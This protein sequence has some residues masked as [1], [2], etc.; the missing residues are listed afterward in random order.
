MS[1]QI[2]DIKEAWIWSLYLIY[3]ISFIPALIASAA[4]LLLSKNP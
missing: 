3:V 2:R 1:K 4:G